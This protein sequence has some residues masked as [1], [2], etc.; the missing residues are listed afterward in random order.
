MSRL[1][2]RCAVLAGF[3]AILVLWPGSCVVDPAYAGGRITKRFNKTAKVR[4]FSPA[5]LTSGTTVLG[6]YRYNP[7]YVQKA[8]RGGH[9]YFYVQEKPNSVK[10]WRANRKFLDRTILRGDRIVLSTPAYWAKMRTGFSRELAYLK[11]RGYTVSHGGTRMLPPAGGARITPLS[12]ITGFSAAA[13][14]RGLRQARQK[15]LEALRARFDGAAS[16]GK[17][18]GRR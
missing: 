3:V 18:A 5:K 12:R 10:E 16:A 17:G 4:R 8:N 13:G 11:S 7:S 9:R 15:R 6:H 1:K 14:N 2:P